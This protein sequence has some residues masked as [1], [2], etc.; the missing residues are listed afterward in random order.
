MQKIGEHA[1]VLG[2][3]MAGLLAAR[4]LSDA[5]G[6]VTV[7][8]RDP[9]PATVEPRRGV[10]QGR[11]AHLLVPCG[12]QVLDGLFPGLLDDLSAAG[13]PVIRDFAEFRFA[14]GGGRRSAARGP[15][16]G[17]VP[18]PG[19][20]AVAGRSRPGP[21]PGAADVE[22]IDRCEVARPDRDRRPRPRHRRTHAAPRR[23]RLEGAS[24]PAAQRR[25]STPTWSSTRPGAAAGPRRGCAAL[26]YDQPRGG[27]ARDQPDVRHAAPSPAP[28]GAGPAKVVGI[29]AVP[30]RPTGFVLFAQ[31]DDRW[32]LTVFGY[33][34][35]TRRRD[36]A[37]FLAFVEAIGPGRCLRRDPR[38]RAARRHRGLPV[39]GQR[40]AALRAAASLPGRVPGLRRRDLQ[41]EPGVRAGHVGGG[42]A[43]G[44]AARHAGR[45]RP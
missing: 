35:T 29:G 27:A 21:G 15:A 17:A 22:I 19:Q 12:T 42:A 1:V 23:R 28:R 11:H 9:L 36:P 14:P 5:Y 4:V 44:G 41:H 38:R 18:L 43:G 20:P 3:G 40:P 6:R 32:I 10:P 25:A 33:A 24:T 30:D 16:G 34:G 8:E 37:G 2:A 26:G 13:V 45:R 7:V 39:P 31:E